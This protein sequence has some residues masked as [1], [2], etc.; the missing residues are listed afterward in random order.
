MTCK[1]RKEKDRCLIC[2]AE[3][4]NEIERLREESGL[5]REVFGQLI[6]RLVEELK[7]E[8]R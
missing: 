7:K 1:H 3:F 5:S 6:R 4:N 8:G 2:W